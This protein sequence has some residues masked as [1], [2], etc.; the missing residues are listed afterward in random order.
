MEFWLMERRHTR[1]AN[2]AFELGFA[3]ASTVVGGVLRWIFGVFGTAA[4]ILGE[5]RGDAGR[6]GGF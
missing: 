1:L 4:A 2:R 6:R 3:A 5:R